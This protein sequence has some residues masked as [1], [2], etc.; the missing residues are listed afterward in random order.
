MACIGD[1]IELEYDVKDNNISYMFKT[2]LRSGD[3][4]FVDSKANECS[5]RVAAVQP[6]TKPGELC[7][8]EGALLARFVKK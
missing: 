2:V 5:Y 3:I 1:S 4:F 6:G 8:R 7:V